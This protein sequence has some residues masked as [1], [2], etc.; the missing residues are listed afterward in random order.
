MSAPASNQ[1]ESLA[2]CALMGA[3]LLAL[4]IA[5]SRFGAAYQDLLLRDLRLGIA[6]LTLHKDV[7]HW[8]N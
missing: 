6:P 5:N 4:A 2:A 7:L 1:R 8:V 3:V